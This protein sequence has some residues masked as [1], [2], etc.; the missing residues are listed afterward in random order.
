MKF[1]IENTVISS[2]RRLSYEAWYAFAEFVDNST[3]AYFDNRKELDKIFS[4]SGRKLEIHITYNRDEDFIEIKDNS[5]GMD[6]IGLDRALKVGLPPENPT[7]R[8]KYGLGMKTAACWFG[9]KWS[10]KT[11]KLGQIKGFEV[12]IDVDSISKQEGEVDI[13]PNEFD[14]PKEEHYTI[15]TIKDLNRKFV[16]RTITKIKEY[17]GSIYRFDLEEGIEIYWNGSKLFY[18]RFEDELHVNEKGEMSKEKFDFMI[19]GKSVK[20]WV[21]VLGKGYGSRKKAGF[22]IVQNKRVIQG[23]PNSFKP[24]S[25]FGEQEDGSNDLV[26]QRVVGELFLDGFPVSH[27]KDKIVWE[28][29]E[30]EQLDKKLG[31]ICDNARNQALTLRFYQDEQKDRIKNFKEEAIAI[32]LNEITSKELSEFITNVEPLPEEILNTSFENIART[33]QN[34]SKPVFETQIENSVKLIVYFNEVSELEPYVLLTKSFQQDI[35]SVIINNLHPV[36]QELES[37]DS[38]VNFLRN[39]IYDGVAEWKSFKLTNSVQPNTVTFV[40]DG[41]LR[42]FSEIRINKKG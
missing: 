27:T 29:D 8:S 17:L 34:E 24:S 42:I 37:T 16:G 18:K 28:D 30:E 1:G 39:C 13:M 35:V 36:I 23:W 22:S 6:E 26:N 19:N 10:I 31:E 25:I 3:Q 40:K 41:L 32:F 20:G 11:K 4:A 38:L 9:N 14:S 12:F 2:Y 33:I 7:Q 15:I 5:I 21:G